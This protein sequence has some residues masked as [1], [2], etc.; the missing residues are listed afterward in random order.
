MLGVV[1]PR[2]LAAVAAVAVKV[3]RQV[4]GGQHGAALRTGGTAGVGLSQRGAAGVVELAA[5]A[6][7]HPEVSDVHAGA[8]E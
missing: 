3:G 1:E 6:A 5:V 2:H 8:V 7:T 4:C